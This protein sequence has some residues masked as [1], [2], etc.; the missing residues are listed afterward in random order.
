MAEAF[1][2]SREDL[3]K[4]YLVSRL[5]FRKDI[6]PEKAAEKLAEI[7]KNPPDANMVFFNMYIHMK[8]GRIFR[9]S[10]GD[11]VIVYFMKRIAED[12]GE[13]A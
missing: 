2:W 1:V 6:T 10:G 8:T 12:D 13:Q 3:E 4:V 5:V 7:I 11:E 9:Q